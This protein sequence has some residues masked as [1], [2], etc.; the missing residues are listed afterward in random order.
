MTK[1]L[2]L[3]N[4]SSVCEENLKQAGY[5]VTSKPKQ[6]EDD[7]CAMLPE[8]DAVAV[9]SGS[10][11]TAKAL[12]AGAGGNLKLVVRVGAGV[13]TIDLDAATRLGVIVENT[14]GTNARGV[15]ELTLAGLL[16]MARQVIPA[17]NSLKEGRWDK[18]KFGGT[19]LQ[20]KTIGIV[21]L[22]NIGQ[23]VARLAKGFGME[24]L[25]FDPV[26]TPER[27]G[28]CGAKLVEL[29][30]LFARADFISLHASLND[31]TRDLV[32]ADSIAK[33]KDGVCI[34][35]CARAGLVKQD[36]L[37][38]ALDSEKV[39]YYYTDV[40]DKEP[41]PEDDPLVKHPSVFMTPHVGGS[42][43]ESAVEGALQAGRQIA[44]YLEDKK[45]INSVNFT[46]G[47]PELEPYEGLAETLG[48][49]VWQ[50]NSDAQGFKEIRITYSGDIAEY[51]PARVSSKF[52]VGLL[53]KTHEGVNIVSAPYLAR[54]MGTKVTV[55]RSAKGTT[56]M[57]VEVVAGKY[58]STYAASMQGVVPVLHS[59]DGH[60]LDLPMGEKH[61][62]FTKHSDVPGIVGIIGTELGKA[63]VN[64]EKMALRDIPGEPS[65]A[66]ISTREPVTKRVLKEIEASVDY[67]GGDIKLKT[68]NF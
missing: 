65:M 18:K 5:D 33:M 6:A 53:T 58:T 51:E 20:D 1:V 44:A 2:L 50:L 27:A 47:D 11:M 17:H 31:A 42:T 39:R 38:A 67:A 68:V 66:V 61:Y 8:Y 10:K 26:V 29:D 64:I 22:G 23:G 7:L 36:D 3:D 16:A 57:F 15:V 49:I 41:P 30:D 25:A 40:F 56:R 9:R 45:V 4:V 54:E 35:N 63:G 12:E 21:G 14:P 24:V 52:F 59:V 34:A 43:A 32:N 48:R 62:L 55:T 13:D 60:E 19:Q 28:E 46:P 37:L